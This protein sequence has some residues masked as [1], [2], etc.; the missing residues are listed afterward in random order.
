MAYSNF[1][2]VNPPRDVLT[3][4]DMY[5]QVD[6]PG[7][8]SIAA[9]YA[10]GAP[11]VGDDAWARAY[12][13]AGL[14][15]ITLRFVAD[16]DPVPLLPPKK[17]GYTPVGKLVFLEALTGTCS[18]PETLHVTSY[19]C[20]SYLPPAPPPH[21]PRPPTGFFGKVWNSIKWVGS[22]L[23]DGVSGGVSGTVSNGKFALKAIAGWK[24]DEPLLKCSKMAAHSMEKV[25]IPYV[26]S[27][28]T[29]SCTKQVLLTCLATANQPSPEQELSPS[30]EGYDAS[31]PVTAPYYMQAEYPYDAATS[32]YGYGPTESPQSDAYGY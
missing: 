8:A 32:P 10:F 20:S 11:S 21:P 5:L 4:A 13:R 1:E 24:T 6:Y 3:N 7:I 29:S 19:S 15:D 17:Y 25:Y 14:W 23:A 31:G 27:L 16:G 2:C 18:L 30:F 9:V 12:K 22:G 26:E 28:C